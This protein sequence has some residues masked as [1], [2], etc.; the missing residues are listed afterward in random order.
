MQLVECVPNF[1][2]GRRPEVVTAIRDA[3]AAAGATVLDASADASHHRSVV[4][5]VAPPERAADAAFAGIA[6]AA[7]LIDL[8]QHTGEHPRLGAADVV[9][10]VPL[11]AWGT[12]MPDCVALARTLGQRVGRE[13]G[14]PVYLYEH[15]A[16]RPDR[17]NLAD[18][19]RGGFEALRRALGSQLDDQLGDPLGER[20]DTQSGTQSG[21]P[22]G[23]GPA[24]A[25]DFGPAAVHPTAGAV[26]VGARN[27]L[28]A[29][30]VYLGPA[31][32]LP[33]ARA[34]ARAVRESSGGLPGVK[35]I[36]LTVDGQAQVSMNL[37]DLDQTNLAAA[38]ARVA[39]EAAARGAAV[40]WSELI[41]LMPERALA[42]TTPER[43]CLRDFSPDRLLEPCIAAAVARR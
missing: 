42:G 32:N 3:I 17:R 18:V 31:S 26:A 22:L 2:E 29:F 4:T 11:P 1:S 40:T 12:A 38:F 27:L 35:A 19:R 21:T 15:A 25:P 20:S 30:N 39:A 8:T 28:V 43:L 16:T 34:V 7:E 24:R 33:V 6:T 13:L 5:F 14:I 9:P 41:G 23:A 37:V 36:G 10:F